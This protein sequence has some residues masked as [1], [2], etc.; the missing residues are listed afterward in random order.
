MLPNHLA[1]IMDGNG[2]W[3]T[4]LDLERTEG[5][6]AGAEIVTDIVT[7]CRK[8][9][10]NY[11]TLYA[12]SEENWGRPKEEVNL[13]MEL[14]F[15]FVIE[16]RKILLDNN[17]HFHPIGDLEKLPSFLKDSLFQLEKDT[18]KNSKMV[19]NLAL[20]YSSRKDILRVIKNFKDS[21]LE[22][23]EKNLTKM[24]YTGNFGEDVDLLIRTG[25][26]KRISN[27]LL[28]EI[29]YAELFFEKSYWP[30]FTPKLLDSILFNFKDR[31]RRYGLIN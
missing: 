22:L 1:I 15:D 20:S 12:F 2:R 13:L 25:G 24:L 31:K 8:I 7:H 29:S 4:A 26:E 16:K 17:I 14:L 11:L 18:Q 9:G 21:G 30:D 28:W 3:A 27:F 23:N 6:K 10:I 19:L 5:H